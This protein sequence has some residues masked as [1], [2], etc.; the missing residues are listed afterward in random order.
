VACRDADVS[1]FRKAWLKRQVLNFGALDPYV[2][3]CRFMQLYKC[4]SAFI[5]RQPSP[6]TDTLGKRPR[7]IDVFLS[8]ERGL[9]VPCNIR[10]LRILARPTL[11]LSSLFRKCERW[12][13][14]TKRGVPLF[15][16]LHAMPTWVGWDLLGD[17]HKCKGCP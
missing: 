10:H 15:F 4:H 12:P 7:A 8:D 6:P 11:Y 9:D 2:A 16:W 14:K 13:F 5:F 3:I 17:A 1:N